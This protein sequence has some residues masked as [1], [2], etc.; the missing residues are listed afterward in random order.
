VHENLCTATAAPFTVGF[1][2]GAEL[3]ANPLKR[4]AQSSVHRT[5][6]RWLA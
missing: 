5:A 6:K 2:D 3:D 1:T 4:E